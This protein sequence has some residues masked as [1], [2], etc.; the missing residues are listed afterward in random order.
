[1][2]IREMEEKDL[3]AVC[4]L[5]KRCFSK[6]WSRASFRSAIDRDDTVYLVCLQQGK[7]AGYCGIWCSF[8]D[9]DL[10]NMAV[11]ADMRRQGIGHSLLEDALRAAKGLGVM[12]MMLEVRC[13]NQAAIALYRQ[14]GFA[15]IGVRG[16]YYTEPTE[17]ALL[18]E[19]R[20]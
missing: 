17:D 2:T 13:S 4:E 16:G 3:D 9:G 5:E 14:F 8:E 20:I 12:R 10:C 1:M 6:P 11:D 15:D 7:I 18:M 19:C